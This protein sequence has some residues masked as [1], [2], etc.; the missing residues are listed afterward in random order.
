MTDELIVNG[1]SLDLSEETPFPINMSINDLKEPDKRARSLSKEIILPYSQ[2][3]H[4]FF[5]SA[6]NLSSITDDYSFNPVLKAPAIYKKNGVEILPNGVLQLKEVVLNNGVPSFKVIIYSEVVDWFLSLTN[7]KVS[8]LDWSAYDHTLSRTNIKNTWLTTAGTG[9]YYP[10]I[11]RGNSRLGTLIWRTTDFVPYVYLYECISKMLEFA[12][13]QWSSTFLNSTRFKNLLFGFGGGD[14]INKSLSPTEL[15]NRK[16]LLTN[17]MFTATDTRTQLAEFAPVQNLVKFIDSS[18]FTVTE[19]QDLFSQ[20]D[21]SNMTFTIQRNGNYKLNFTGTLQAAFSGSGWTWSE[22]GSLNI[23]VFKNNQ[24][25]YST[26]DYAQTSASQSHA[27]SFNV[28][29]SCQSGDTIR[30]I[31]ASRDLKGTPLNIPITRNITT[32][33]PISIT[34]ESTDTSVTDG[35]TISLNKFMPDMLCSDLFVSV[36]KHF[37]LQFSDPDI[38][39][40]STIEPL[41]TFYSQT[42]IFDDITDYVDL[43]NEISVKPIAN[44]YNKVIRYRF[45]DV[46]DFDNNTYLQKYGIEYGNYDAQNSSYY[47]KGEQKI[48]LAYSTIIPY[49]ISPNIVVPRFITK[50]N[51]GTSKPTDSVPRV[52]FRCA[53]KTGTWTLRDAVGSGQ[54]TLTTYP[55]VHHFDA[56]NNPTFDLNFQLVAEVFYTATSVTTQN[57]FSVYHEDFVEEVTTADGKL[58]TL[59]VHWNANDVKRRDFSKLIMYNGVLFR[60]NKIMDFDD[61]ISTVTKIE[62]VKVLKAKSKNRRA[63]S[64]VPVRPTTIKDPQIANP[65]GVGVG[66]PVLDGG[67]KGQVLQYVPIKRLG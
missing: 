44:E 54:E 14:Y 32:S 46:K 23:L 20:F 67:S 12:G 58:V 50:D 31:V 45:K 55:L 34:L 64:V 41:D 4:N 29:L 39:G 49:E 62:L 7:I 66:V 27:F 8:E 21:T 42:S 24:Q 57:A 56:F 43:N 17:G 35:S 60:L 3:N 52:M 37:N 10:L 48:E 38:Y 18:T 33:L 36:M 63:V 9:Y 28:N 22:G 65:V 2:T 53:M 51:T 59:Y 26:A 25:V 19:S 5:I 13:V 30:M 1:I 40:V 11:E 16:V 6:F 47:S 61:N 15:N